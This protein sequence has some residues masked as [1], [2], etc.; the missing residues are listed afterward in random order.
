MNND[1]SR[2]QKQ[3]TMQKY[4]M[5]ALAV[6]CV[7]PWLIAAEP[8]KPLTTAEIMSLPRNKELKVGEIKLVGP[9]GR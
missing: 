7:L 9:F 6:M 1:V 8:I 5:M 2:L 4:G 3:I